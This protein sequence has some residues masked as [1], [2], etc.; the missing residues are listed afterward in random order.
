MVPATARHLV[1]CSSLDKG[2]DVKAACKAGCIGCKLCEK[3]CEY[4][5]I[6]VENNLAYIDYGKCTNCGKCAVVCPVKVIVVEQG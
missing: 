3:A 2:K 6:H 1:A 4:D 5:A